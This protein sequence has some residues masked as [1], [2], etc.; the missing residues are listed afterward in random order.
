MQ[1]D[2]A[3]CA[4]ALLVL[5][6]RARL[7]KRQHLGRHR[8]ELPGV[9]QLANS[10][11][12]RVAGLDYPPEA[13]R[14][15]AA[16]AGYSA[17]RLFVQRATQIQPGL[18]LPE[19]SIA[20]IVRICQH[21]AGMPLAIELAAASVRTLPIAE[22][23]RQISANIDALTTIYHDMP[24]QHRSMRAVFEHSCCAR[25]PASP[26]RERQRFRTRSVE[27]SNGKLA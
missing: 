27:A 11:K 26:F 5:V 13:P 7:R 23:E 16:L 14:E 3:G 24:E 6:G 4:P 19:S 2:L 1:H 25:P 18:R 12:L 21:V 17:V 8:P 20:A 9:D 15:P 22:I 10:H